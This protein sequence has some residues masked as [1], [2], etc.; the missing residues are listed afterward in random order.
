VESALAAESIEGI[1]CRLEEAMADFHMIEG[2]Q[3]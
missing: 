2:M 3:K 1:I